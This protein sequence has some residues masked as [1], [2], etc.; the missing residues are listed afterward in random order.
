MTGTELARADP[1]TGNGDREP[2]AKASA[3]AGLAQGTPVMA[4][5]SPRTSAPRDAG[6]PSPI[7]GTNASSTFHGRKGA[8][9]DEP[10]APPGFSSPLTLGHLRL[11]SDISVLA[12]VAP[13]QLG[14]LRPPSAISA[15]VRPSPAPSS[16]LPAAERGFPSCFPSTIG[17]F[18]LRLRVFPAEGSGISAAGS[19]GLGARRPRSLR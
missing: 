1:D 2:Q 13:F 11:R 10:Q 4:A 19:A 17:S 18:R 9:R 15:P 16:F 6:I 8:L 5:G 12:R 3:G 7:C 14:H